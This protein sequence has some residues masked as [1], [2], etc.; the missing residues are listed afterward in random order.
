VGTTGGISSFKA[1]VIGALMSFLCCLISI[2]SYFEKR[3]K[4]KND[5]DEHQQ[6]KVQAADSRLF[7]LLFGLVFMF[8]LFFVLRHFLRG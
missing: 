8:F 5:P 7:I 2:I 4:L 3:K 6:L 1:A